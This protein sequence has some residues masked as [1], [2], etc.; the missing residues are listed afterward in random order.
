MRGLAVSAMAALFV[1]AAP[2]GAQS[3]D[4]ASVIALHHAGLGDAPIL[5]KIRALPCGFDTSVAALTRLKQAGISDRVMAAMVDRCAVADRP[6]APAPSP[7][8]ARMP[9]ADEGIYLVGDP[10]D[11]AQATLLRPSGPTSTKVSGNGSLLFPTVTRLVVPQPSAQA[12]TRQVRPIFLFR[13][14]PEDHHVSSFGSAENWVAQSPSEF[15][16]VRFALE[17]GN[18][19]LII[20]R[21]KPYLQVSGAD[22]RQMLP[23]AVTDLGGGAFRVEV[24]QDLVPGE[25][26]FLLVG[27]LQRRKESTYRVYDFAVRP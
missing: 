7:A 12:M 19:Q 9:E 16:L 3:F 20:G 27:E 23:F 14:K 5:A 22:P 15:S 2:A 11:P 13:F 25:Y 18:R 24:T 21:T 26:G 6:A 10:T 4:N 8:A 1:L 17:G